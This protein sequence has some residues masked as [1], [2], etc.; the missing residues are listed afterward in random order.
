MSADAEESSAAAAALVSA[1]HGQLD[2]AEPSA[3]AAAQLVPAAPLVVEPSAASAPAAA[4]V[5]ASVQGTFD[6]CLAHC[7]TLIICQV[8]DKMHLLIAF[9]K[10]VDLQLQLNQQALPGCTRTW[11]EVASDVAAVVDPMDPADGAKKSKHPLVQEYYHVSHLICT[12]LF[13]AAWQD[14]LLPTHGSKIASFNVFRQLHSCM[15]RLYKYLGVGKPVGTAELA[16][17]AQLQH[18]VISA[19]T[20]LFT[21]CQSPRV[22]GTAVT[23]HMA[24]CQFTKCQSAAMSW[25]LY[26]ALSLN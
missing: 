17:D 15:E 20:K 25:S 8:I 1:G 13:R 3:V 2:A 18:T 6:E 12:P 23:L 19:W 26:E 7:K 14:T 5:A 11:S 9:H 4:D 10:L 21:T 16:L 24:K 22:N